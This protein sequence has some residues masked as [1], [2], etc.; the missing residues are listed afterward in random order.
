[1]QIL[2]VLSKKFSP[3]PPFT[4]TTTQPGI[5]IIRPKTKP[6]KPPITGPQIAPQIECSIPLFFSEA[7]VFT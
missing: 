4:A 5:P 6:H 1:M 2:A 3:E 7:N